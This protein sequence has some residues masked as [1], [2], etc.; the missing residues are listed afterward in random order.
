[1]ITLGWPSLVLLCAAVAIPLFGLGVWL[2]MADGFHREQTL[3]SLK[4]N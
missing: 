1:M 2:T 3:P 4:E